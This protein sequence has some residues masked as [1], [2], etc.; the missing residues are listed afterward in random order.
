V[1]VRCPARGEG[2]R[3]REESSLRI[4]VE[5]E[6]NLANAELLELL[7][8]GSVGVLERIGRAESRPRMSASTAGLG[9]I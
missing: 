7:S 4:G 6:F 2:W 8:Q 5:I 1:V 3:V 9:A